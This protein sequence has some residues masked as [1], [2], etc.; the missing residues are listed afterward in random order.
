VFF[1]SGVQI[2]DHSRNDAWLVVVDVFLCNV[3]HASHTILAF[4]S[5]QASLIVDSFYGL[6]H[7][8]LRFD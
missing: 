2:V 1:L 5:N 7:E 6:L 3:L 8:K 4:F